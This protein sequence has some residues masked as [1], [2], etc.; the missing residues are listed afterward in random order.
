MFRGDPDLTEYVSVVGTP[1]FLEFVESVRAEGVELERAPMG[2]DTA[3]KRPLLVEVDHLDPEKDIAS[4]DIIIP[5][6]SGRIQRQVKNLSD[7]DVSTI[8]TGKFSL[9]NFTEDQQREIVFLD[10]DTKQP[11]WTTDLGAE[12]IP[13]PQSV[14]AYLASELLRRM[15]MVGGAPVLYERLKQYIPTRLFDVPVNLED[16]NVLRNLSELGPRRH[17]FE[18]FAAAINNLTLVDVGTAELI[19]EISIAK[20]RPSVVSNQ[21]YTVSKKT[22]FNRVIGDSNLELRF[23]Q[24]LDHAVDVQSFAKNSKSVHFFIEYV[25]S[26]GEISH[27]YPDFVVRAKDGTIFVI[28]TKG[29]QD[30]DV[31]PKWR[32]LVQWCADAS[33]IQG[34]KVSYR[35]LFM[36]EEDFNEIETRTKSFAELVELSVNRK[37]LGV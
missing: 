5:R 10:L 13:T 25:S 37:P 30:L 29:L 31:A 27:Y 26:T 12:V 33:I 19:S 6:L 23:A 32:R 21:E 16:P 18:T 36:T 4:L 2:L 17:L 7:L 9:Q 24:F 8:S 20:T 11:A 35:P 34:A 3:P 22:V 1:A 28:E 14:L 15:R